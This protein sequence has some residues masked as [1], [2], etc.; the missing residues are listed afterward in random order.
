MR[1]TKIF[2]IA[3]LL[4]CSTVVARAQFLMDMIDTTTELGKGMISMYQKYDALRFS[5]YIQP[6]F[7]MAQARGASSYAGGDFPPA[8]DNRFMLRRG[9]IRVDYERYNKDN[10]PLVQFAFQF[11]GTERGVFIRDFYGRFFETKFNVLSLAAGM[12][13]RPFGYEVNLSSADRETPERG[14]MSQILMKTERDM[15][16]M[17]SFEPRRKDHPLSFLK[18][19]AGLFNGQGLTGPNDFDSHK[20]FIGRIAIKP[21]KIRGTNY[22][23]S[24]GVSILYGGMEQFTQYINT[25]GTVNGKPGYTVDSAAGNV[26]KIAPRHYFG[27]DIQLKIPNG[28][29]KGSTQ[30]RAE[31]IRGKQTATAL[32][33][34]TPGIIPLTPQGKPQPLYIRNFD[35]AYLYF[36]Q[37]LGSDKHQVVVKYDWY[38]PNKDVKGKDIGMPGAGLT[39][40]DIRYNTLG[41]GYLYYAN[42]HLKFMFYYD[43]VTNES[44]ELEGYK[45]DLKDNVLTCRIQYRF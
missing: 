42:E 21:C 11:D 2:V 38:D 10:M 4:L 20:D 41:V 25:M 36:L 3:V 32:T 23:L 8:V 18:I 16:A 34:E 5:G 45:K 35:G 7:Q 17:V 12:F 24:A 39:A 13:A 37:N 6:Q 22:L 40:A 31:Y 15:G 1:I 26:G 9:R 29:G 30:F 43:W 19:D 33:T 44:T 14:R 27:A 28:P